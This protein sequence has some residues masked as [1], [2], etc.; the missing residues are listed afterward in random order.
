MLINLAAILII[1]LI[2]FSDEAKKEITKVLLLILGC[3]VQSE[4][5]EQF[6]ENIK[7][8]QVEVQHAIVEFIKEVN[9]FFALKRM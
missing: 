7:Q 8:L 6:I 9:T 1:K 4:N 2:C 5:K 3:A